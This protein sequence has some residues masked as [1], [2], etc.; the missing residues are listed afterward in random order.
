MGGQLFSSSS[1]RWQ[2]LFELLSLWLQV[3]ADGGHSLCMWPLCS[4]DSNAID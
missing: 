1:S 3:A 4:V 2:A